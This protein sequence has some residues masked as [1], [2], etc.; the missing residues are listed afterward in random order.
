[1]FIR[2]VAK[3]PPLD[4]SVNVLP[5]R[6]F[7][8]FYYLLSG[9]LLTKEGVKQHD[10]EEEKR[11]RREASSRRQRRRGRGYPSDTSRQVGSK[12]LDSLKCFR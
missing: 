4:M 9:R 11:R 8:L 7:E 2:L 5:R 6:R 1:M 10:D 12:I 3:G